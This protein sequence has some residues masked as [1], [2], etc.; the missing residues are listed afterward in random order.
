VERCIKTGG[1][2]WFGGQKLYVSRA[3]RG[4]RVG[5]VDVDVDVWV[6]HFAGNDLGLFEPGDDKMQPLDRIES[7][8]HTRR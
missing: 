2:L 6:V 4:H 5:L 3:L 8:L 1:Y 7:Y